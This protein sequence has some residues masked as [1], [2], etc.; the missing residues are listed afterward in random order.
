MVKIKIFS[1]ILNVSNGKINKYIEI[2]ITA[3]NTDKMDENKT[4]LTWKKLT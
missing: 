2:G 4:T 3:K 1:K